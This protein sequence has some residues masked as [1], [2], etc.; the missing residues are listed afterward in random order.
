[1]ADR[2][3]GRA[4]LRTEDPRFL[5]GEARYVE[6]IPA[7]GA[8]R[9]V[10][11]RS[12]TAHAHLRGV[13]AG[14]AL[15]APGVVAVWTAADVADL[16][17]I[18]VPGSV[19]EP[20]A[21]ALP[22]LATDRV[23]WVGQPI[24]VVVADSLARALDAAELV[25]PDLDPLD[26]LV[27]P[28]AAL[29]DAGTLLFPEAGSNVAD[30]FD[31][32]FDDDAVLAGAEIVVCERV[33]HQ[34][35][36][37]VPMET[38]AMLAEPTEDGGLLVHVSTQVPFDVRNDL[39]DALDLDRDRIRVIAPDVGGGFGTKLYVYPEYLL[40]AALARRLGRAVRWSES[41]SESMTALLHGRAQ[42]HDVE[43]AAR[44]DGTIVGLRVDLVADMGAHPLG[45][46]LPANTKRMLSGPYRI[47][48]IAL[49]VR[50]VVTTTTP[51]GSYRG[52]GRPEATLTLERMLDRLAGELGLDPIE[53][54][55]RNLIPADAFPYEVATGERY[56]SGDYAAALDRALA[57][58][59]VDALRVEQAARRGRGDRRVLGIGVAMYVEITGFS[60]ED[61]TVE[62][63]D[64][65]GI[66]VLV[67]TS[68]HGQGHETAFAQLVGGLLA[69]PIERV[70]VVHSDTGR[71]PRGQG[72]YASR[73]L[74][75]G[76]SAIH[77]GA[78]AVIDR[79]K[80][81]VAED[82]EVAAEDLEVAEAGV[83]VTGA[84]DR[85]RTWAQ[86]ARLARDPARPDPAPLRAATRFRM[87]DATFPFGAH[88]AVVEVDLD[89]G[90]VRLVRH[91]AVDDAGVILN[92]LLAEG[93]VHGGLAQGAAQA[94]YEEVRFDPDGNPLT[95]TL[96]SYP[97]PAAS[98]LPAWETAFTQTPTP[99]NP[100]GA[101]GIGESATVGSTPAIQSAVVDAL[102]HLGIVH[103]DVPCTP[104]RVLAAIRD[105]TRG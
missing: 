30:G 102:A 44:R 1:M 67:G 23:R 96:A 15:A 43:L 72:T 38:N 87:D 25:V 62:V 27:D 29:D 41:R 88:V 8:L 93:Q 65:G 73:S 32:R 20:V 95:T 17:P 35:L 82:L 26:P 36:A 58:A 54:R 53:V 24:A 22:L 11:V 89:D 37:P 91:I 75:V 2:V 90:D 46:Y 76:G 28:M 52:A 5:R 74:Q 10:V 86:I 103:V 100:L 49:R 14:G 81:L 39:A 42:V 78:V 45:S 57:L 47:P 51:I 55:R 48:A 92:P 33:V 59:D 83:R 71:V 69:V 105:A 13:D 18:A 50:S 84:P 63:D 6:D 61:A 79:A 21:F 12:H 85:A 9:A 97:M 80:A 3:F 70:R 94:L 77:E 60:P 34:R 56:D 40:V 66:T 98:D 64:D 7:P 68:P 104:E 99:R 16:P 101:K 31:D 4:V 19:R